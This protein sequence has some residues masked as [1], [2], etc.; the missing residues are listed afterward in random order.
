MPLRGIANH[1]VCCGPIEYHNVVRTNAA[2]LVLD[3]YY[4]L[5]NIFQFKCCFNFQESRKWFKS[6]GTRIVKTFLINISPF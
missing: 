5:I 4:R 3:G 1:G 2:V 6:S